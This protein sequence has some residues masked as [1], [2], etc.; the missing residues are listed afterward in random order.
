MASVLIVAGGTGRAAFRATMLRIAVIAPAAIFEAVVGIGV[1]GIPAK[2]A[3]CASSVLG[4]RVIF[5]TSV[6]QRMVLRS[7]GADVGIA[8]AAIFFDCM[9]RFII[10]IV[11]RACAVAA[12]LVFTAT[13]A[14]V[15]SAIASMLAGRVIFPVT[16]RIRAVRRAPI[17][18][19][20]AVPAN[21]FP[22][23]SI[24]RRIGIVVLA[25]RIFFVAAFGTNTARVEAM[26]L[27]VAIRILVCAAIRTALPD[28]MLGFILLLIIVGEAARRAVTARNAASAGGNHKNGVCRDKGDTFC[29]KNAHR[30]L[31]AGYDFE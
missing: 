8:D 21:F 16:I 25:G 18:D 1:T 19:F 17:N 7:A 27:R 26:G 28:V 10:F 3:R 30:D 4:I 24:P 29:V 13:A 31:I 15:A 23:T 22:I 6:F 14:I 20:A 2:A 9:L 5:P 11:F 12:V